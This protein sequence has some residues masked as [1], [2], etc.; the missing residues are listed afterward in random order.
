MTGQ[1]PLSLWGGVIVS[2][3]WM[4]LKASWDENPF[5]QELNELSVS[6]SVGRLHGDGYRLG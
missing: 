6:K 2:G 5:S 4:F 3:K 1:G